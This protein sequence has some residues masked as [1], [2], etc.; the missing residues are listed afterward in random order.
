MANE[1]RNR[2]VPAKMAVTTF[3]REA[4]QAVVRLLRTILAVAAE[5]EGT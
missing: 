1:W 3:F 2:G 5:H 4:H